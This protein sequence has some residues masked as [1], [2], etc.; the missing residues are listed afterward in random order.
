[1]A[2]GTGAGSDAAGHE[3]TAIAHRGRSPCYRG[4]AFTPVHL[5]ARLR[6][7][8]LANLEIPPIEIA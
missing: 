8:F 1:M 7:Y 5:W 6:R 2:R 3:H 4:T